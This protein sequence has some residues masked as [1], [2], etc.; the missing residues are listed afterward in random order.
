MQIPNKSQ[1]TTNAYY[2]INLGG[3]YMHRLRDLREDKDLKQKELADYLGCS[4]ATYS[5]YETGALGVPSDILIK[6]AKFYK[7]TVDYILELTDEKNCHSIKK[8]IQ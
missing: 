3:K 8:E 6:L 5:R 2:K 4:Q 7:V 1:Y